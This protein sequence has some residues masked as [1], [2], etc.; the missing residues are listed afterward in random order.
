M[1]RWI[2]CPRKTIKRGLKQQKAVWM[3][4]M[5]KGRKIAQRNFP[6]PQGIQVQCSTDKV[7]VLPDEILVLPDDYQGDNEAWL[8]D[9]IINK[10]PERVYYTKSDSQRLEKFLLEEQRSI[11][12]RPKKKCRLHSQRC[13][14]C[15]LLSRNTSGRENQLIKDSRKLLL[16]GM[17][18]LMPTN[19]DMIHSRHMKHLRATLSMPWGIHGK[20]YGVH[21]SKE[22]FH[23]R[24]S[25]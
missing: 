14:T 19:T 23:C 22:V 11:W 4:Q 9:A 13:E 1:K 12:G 20:W 18:S 25:K 2:N 3:N 21:T 15:D 10:K 8:Q 16:V 17:W 7:L 5:K 24:S 6:F